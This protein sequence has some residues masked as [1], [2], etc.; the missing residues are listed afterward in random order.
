MLLAFQSLIDASLPMRAACA[1]AA[2]NLIIYGLNQAALGVQ[3]GAPYRDP[4]FPGYNR[5]SANGHQW[6]LVVDWIYNAVGAQNQPILTTADKAV[7]QQA[8]QRFNQPML[9]GNVA[10]AAMM[11]GLWQSTGLDRASICRRLCRDYGNG[12]PFIEGVVDQR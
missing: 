10:S 1:Q 3:A 9:F 11:F 7:I 6:A 8:L 5:A 12:S 4:Q 2:R